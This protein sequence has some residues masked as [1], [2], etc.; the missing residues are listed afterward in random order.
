MRFLP[1]TRLEVSDISGGFEYLMPTVRLSGGLTLA[2]VRTITGLEQSTIQ[3][4]I[5]RGWVA[6]PENK[7][8]GEYQLARIIIINMLRPGMLLDNI[9]KLLRFING[10]AE[11]RED[12]IIPDSV[13]Y[14]HLC[15]VIAVCEEK[16]YSR[17]GDIRRVAEKEIDGYSEAFPG[18]REKLCSALTVMTMTFLAADILASMEEIYNG[19][20]IE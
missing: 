7:R 10:D 1:G 12:D 20:D 15:A 14:S 4:W 9:A 11:N 19:L 16:Q 5:K 13:L 2:Q 18:A 6:H 3:N 8:Y 17:A